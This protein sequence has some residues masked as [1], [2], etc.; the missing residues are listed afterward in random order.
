MYVCFGWEKRPGNRKQRGNDVEYL[1]Y[2]MVFAGSALMA[3]NIFLYI[4]FAQSIRKHGDWARERR[5]L[6]IPIFLLLMFLAGYLVVGI[7]GKPDLVVSGILFGG[8][9]F[10]FVI[11]WL[12]RRIVARVQANEHLEAKLAAAEEA[13]KAKTFFLS[14]MT[15]DI[16]TPL[17]AIIGY[18]TLAK[19][20][21]G[22][23]EKQMEYVGKIEK[24][25]HQLLAIVNNVLEMSRIESGKIELDSKP[26]DLEEFIH[27]AG[28]LMRAQL[29]EKSISF[30]S[31]CKVCDKWALCDKNL[32]SRVITNLLGN[33]AKFT[34][35][36]GTITLGLKQISRIEGMGVYEFRVKDTGIGMDPA[37]VEHLFSPFERE[38]TSTVSRIQG[39]G[40]GM[41]IAKNI[42][43]MMGGTIDVVTEK[44]KGTEFIINVSFPIEKP[45]ED[46]NAA[47]SAE[48][49][50]DGMRALLVEDNALNTEIACLLLTQAGFEIDVAENGQ[51][52]V[53]KVIA[54]ESGYYDV[55]LMD[56]Q[57]PVMDGYTAAR[58]IRALPDPTLSSIPIVAMTANAFIEDVKTAEEA[59]MN[60]HIAKPLNVCDMFA[61]LK[62]VMDGKK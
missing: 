27:E 56:I 15:H 6:N 16:R 18:T 5:I 57:M 4:R 47:A 23:T 32:L 10:V 1:I 28:D 7:F 34:G 62:S 13:N 24:A 35:E 53:E 49:R 42:I 3:Y 12:I 50:F 40:L 14:N 33:A 21:Q 25:S 2:S 38:Q 26:T 22:N 58:A 30:S 54:S 45:D 19:K 8:S 46:E 51:I 48:I 59:G 9:V 20:E 52:A 55:I 41:S 60:G 37:F 11:L 29:A 39:T 61:T 44:G 36:D 17:N 31:S 43:D